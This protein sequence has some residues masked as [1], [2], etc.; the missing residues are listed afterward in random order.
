MLFPMTEILQNQENSKNYA[1]ES[2]ENH[3][4]SKFKKP[5]NLAQNFTRMQKMMTKMHNFL[6]WRSKAR[7]ALRVIL[8]LSLSG[9]K[10]SLCAKTLGEPPAGILD[11]VAWHSDVQ[12]GAQSWYLKFHFRMIIEEF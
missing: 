9:A 8:L 1:P 12:V 11:P 6:S 7:A 10:H 4:N 3:A 5:R 2:F